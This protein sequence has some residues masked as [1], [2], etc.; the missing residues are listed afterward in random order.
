MTMT[1]VEAEALPPSV[2]VAVTV[3][4]CGEAGAVYWPVALST[5]P[6]ETVQFAGAVAANCNISFTSTVG[7]SGWIANAVE[8]P[9]SVTVCGVLAALSENVTMPVRVPV[10]VGVNTMLTVQLAP[11]T[12]YVPQ[13]FP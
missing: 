8:P 7:L 6:Q 12:R 9:V 3:Q 4:V 1:W 13:V 5:V 10:A 2:S 11:E